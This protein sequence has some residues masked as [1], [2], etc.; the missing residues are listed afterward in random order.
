MKQNSARQRVPEDWKT[1]PEGRAFDSFNS[2]G[3]VAHRRGKLEAWLDRYFHDIPP[4]KREVFR[5][6]LDE[7]ADTPKG[8]QL[9]GLWVR[10][11]LLPVVNQSRTDNS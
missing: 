9:L 6:W 10:K 1:D 5:R 3:F 4:E 11:T 8:V 7:G 2:I